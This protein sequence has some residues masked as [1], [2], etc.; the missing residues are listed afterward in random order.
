M[1]K[2]EAQKILTEQLARFSAR[3]HSELKRFVEEE[4]VEAYE[5]CGPLGTAYQVE[6]QFIWDDTPGDTIRIL[7]SVDD[8]G[9]RAFFR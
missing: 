5:V 9:L 1:N 6:I 4:R 7:G 8:G 2:S 3:S